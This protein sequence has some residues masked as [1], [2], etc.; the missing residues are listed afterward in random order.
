MTWVKALAA[1]PRRVLRKL[2]WTA[3]APRIR[4]SQRRASALLLEQLAAMPSPSSWEVPPPSLDVLVPLRVHNEDR[5]LMLT[6]V[7]RHL[8]PALRDTDVGVL[9]GDASLPEWSPDVERLWSGSGLAARVDRRTEPMPLRVLDLLA[10][11][12]A[13]HVMLQFDDMITAG[14]DAGLLASACALLQTGLVDV[15]FPSWPLSV[16]VEDTTERIVVVPF[17]VGCNG[18]RFFAGRPRQPVA[19]LTVGDVTYGIFESFTYGF[20]LNQLVTRREDLR[21]R[22]AWFVDHVSAESAH[23]I[24]LVA[25]RGKGPAWNHLA[26]PLAGVAT[27]DLDYA[28]TEASVRAENPQN[29]RVLE[30]VRAGWR[31]EI[32]PRHFGAPSDGDATS[33]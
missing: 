23:R 19:V 31:I 4:A 15:V 28:H 10:E 12:A 13:E 22:L 27:I 18:H 1:L 6:E 8:G 20:F 24:E 29:R 26:V 33:A 7:V 3:A 2:S 21:A 17:E 11:S 32:V 9:V 30:A 5:L 16:E 14:L 25:A